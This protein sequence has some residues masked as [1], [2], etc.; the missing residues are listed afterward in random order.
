MFAHDRRVLDFLG[1][2]RTGLQFSGLLSRFALAVVPKLSSALSPTSGN[3]QS[4]TRE[5]QDA[6]QQKK[7][8]LLVHQAEIVNSRTG[9]RTDRRVHR[10]RNDH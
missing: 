4:D 9:A 3:R 5:K 2:I 1:A 7:V 6:A 8:L 10:E